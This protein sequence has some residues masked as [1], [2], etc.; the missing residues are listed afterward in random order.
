MITDL[1]L[2]FSFVEAPALKNLLE[3]VGRRK[4]LIPKTRQ[5]MN[6]LGTRF[7]RM[8]TNL[9]ALLH[10]QE[11][12]CLTCDVWS[13]RA[14]SYMGM[15]VHFISKNYD[16]RSYVLAFRQLKYKQTYYELACMIDDIILEYQIP[17]EKL[18]NVVTDGGS[19]F[20]KAFRIFGKRHDTLVETNV[21]IDTEIEAENQTNSEAVDRGSIMLQDL[22]FMQNSDG[23]LFFS[24]II[25]L[26]QENLNSMPSDTQLDESVLSDSEQN[27]EDE[28]NFF[29]DMR[30]NDTSQANSQ[31]RVIN[32][33]PQRR[34]L[35]HLLNLISS[36]FEKALLSFAR[37]ALIASVNKLHSLWI[38]THR[39][40]HAKTICLEVLG[41]SLSVPCETRWNSK[42]DAIELACDDKIKP[43]INILIQRLKISLNGASH[44]Q[45]VSSNDWA[46][47]TEYLNVM[48]PIA[49]SLDRL[50]SEKNGAQGYVLPTL[51]AMKHHVEKVNGNNI[52]NQFKKTMIDVINSRFQNYLLISESNRDLLLA[53]A[54]LPKF[55]NNF[56]ENE[57]DKQLDHL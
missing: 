20:C 30:E 19:A 46:V 57:M 7:D 40:S 13:S 47:L 6:E 44:L 56:L 35:S 15:T 28:V 48:K 55:K 38:F 4:I 8:K 42:Y 33:P 45:L 9:I 37:S 51:M 29:R 22:P 16:R 32:L 2:P 23:E 3:I 11:Y 27:D 18:T 43:N 25:T 21:T 26:E 49:R 41:R 31:N 34:C 52:A 12:L 39:S 50:Q 24:N 53:T 5:F 36:D 14:C 54:T 1:N 10:Q 17:K